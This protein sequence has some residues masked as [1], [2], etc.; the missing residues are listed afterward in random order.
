MCMKINCECEHEAKL[1]H[2][3]EFNIRP[4]FYGLHW[5]YSHEE[6]DTSLSII[7]HSGSYGHEKGLFETQCSWKHDVQGRL[8]FGQVQ[9]TMDMFW[10]MV[11]AFVH[12][13]K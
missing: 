12:S 5:V 13:E 3:V 2:G 1:K 4:H 7:C 6:S 11:E 10:L 9:N 8:T